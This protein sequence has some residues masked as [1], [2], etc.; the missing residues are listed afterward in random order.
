MLLCI[1]LAMET[2]GARKWIQAVCILPMLGFAI[3]ALLWS[4]RHPLMPPAHSIFAQPYNS[5]LFTDGELELKNYLD[6]KP[7]EKGGIVIGSDN[8]DY[9]YYKLLAG[10]RGKFH[11]LKHVLVNNESRIYLDD[12]IP[13]FII[14]LE[15][16]R[17]SYTIAG[18]TY[19]RTV[20]FKEGP[21]VFEPR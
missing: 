16:A 6:S 4:E 3:G 13:D 20:V 18:K 8:W 1:P 14:S 15:K 7:Y 21:A 19:Y 11:I 10:K 5:F 9:P 17:D 12:F 2:A